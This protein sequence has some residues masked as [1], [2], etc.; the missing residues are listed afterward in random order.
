M[1]D[2]AIQNIN[3]HPSLDFK[4]ILC[5]SIMAYKNCISTIVLQ[6]ENVINTLKYF[7]LLILI[8][9]LVCAGHTLSHTTFLFS[10][11]NHQRL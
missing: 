6:K 8:L 1:I 2:A 11:F 7:I 4:D 5:A 3:Q 10:V 9:I